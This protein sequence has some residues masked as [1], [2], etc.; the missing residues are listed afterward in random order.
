LDPLI[1]SVAVTGGEHGREATPHLPV[2][3]L[4]I[5]ESALEAHEAGA[6]VVHIHVRDDQEQPVHDLERYGYVGAWL[7][8]RSDMI[9]NLTT[10]PGA[11]I[12]DLDR[13]R[14]L[15]LEPE[16]ASFDAGTMSWGE[17]VMN[18]SLPF[19]RALATRMR[20]T[21]TK[22]ELEVFHDGMVGTCL[23]LA[24]EGLLD[25]PLYFQFVLGAGGGAPATVAELVHLLSMIPPG[26][27]WSVTGIGRHGVAMAMAAIP[28]G[29]H[30]RVG[31][32][33]QIYASRGVLARTNA[34][35]VERVVRLAGEFGRPVATPAQ[36][37]EILGLKGADHTRF[38]VAASRA[39]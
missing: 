32:E 36:A 14:S 21:N 11:D 6:A 26:G 23:R 5:A 20:E 29:G 8:E 28:M 7:R 15:D 31:L 13:L 27:P 19:L 22:P 9:V 3:P 39:S 35:L 18:G 34:E 37:R 10:D 33:D 25:S 4:Q 24:E 1:I 2:T 30:V 17:R 16:L 12:P 38:P